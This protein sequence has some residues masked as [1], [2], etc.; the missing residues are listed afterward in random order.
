MKSCI[1]E[2]NSQK[3]V[4]FSDYDQIHNLSSSSS[5]RSNVSSNS[6][7]SKTQK[8]TIYYYFESKD[9]F[10]ELI[11]NIK[12]KFRNS[13]HHPHRTSFQESENDEFHDTN[14][15]ELQVIVDATDEYIKSLLNLQT[16]ICEEVGEINS[17]I[18]FKLVHKEKQ[19]SFQNEFRVNE[20]KTLDDYEWYKSE[21]NSEIVP[22]VRVIFSRQA[23]DKS[24]PGIQKAVPK[25]QRI[26]SRDKGPKLNKL[27]EFKQRQDRPRFNDVQN[28]DNYRRPQE[29]EFD[30]SFINVR[31][32][33][34]PK[35]SSR[36]NNGVFFNE[37]FEHYDDCYHSP[38][39]R[40]FSQ[41]IIYQTQNRISEYQFQEPT[42]QRV[43][44]YDRQLDSP[45]RNQYQIKQGYRLHNQ[46]RQASHGYNYG[47]KNQLGID[48]NEIRINSLSNSLLDGSPSRNEQFSFL[49]IFNIEQVEIKEVMNIVQVIATK[50]G[51]ATIQ[52]IPI[53]ILRFRQSIMM[54]TLSFLR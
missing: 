24:L 12:N 36:S 33:P 17:L 31:P 52:T 43:Y 9:Q 53:K 47:L 7:A 44:N 37:N 54:Q 13:S 5:Q 8:R 35:N 45:V 4:M 32:L 40:Q 18:Q 50:V 25:L 22:S 3:R 27:I 11:R 38:I 1:K 48:L 34:T 30:E 21:W 49:T 2:S 10:K 23:F 20:I 28:F 42:F 29:I 6:S 51:P 16:I 41:P 14:D 19:R 26:F 46:R 39:Q 15:E